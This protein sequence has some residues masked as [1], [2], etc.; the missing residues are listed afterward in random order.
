MFREYLTRN[1]RTV[2]QNCTYTEDLKLREDGYTITVN[3]KGEAA[4]TYHGIRGKKYAEETLK[5]LTDAKGQTLICE[6][7]DYPSFA[8]RGIIEGFYGKPYTWEE[9][10]DAIDFMASHKMN[11]YF[12]APKEDRYHRDL[13]RESYPVDQIQMIGEMKRR[14]EEKYVR[15]YYCMSPGKDF[16]FT[17][18]A[19]YQSLLRKFEEVAEVGVD[20]FAILFDDISAEL[21]EEEKIH[22]TSAAHAHCH[23][24]NWLNKHLKH[25]HKLVICPTDYMQNY[26]TPYREDLRKYL[27]A[28]IQVFWTGY[29]AV[30]EVLPER[31]CIV[32]RDTFQRE[33]V[34]WDNYPVNDYFPRGR[35]YMDAICNRTRNIA[36]YHEG[37]VSNTSGLW[38]SSKFMLVSF[39]KWM[40]NAE[41]YDS[42]QAYL[43]TLDELVG[44]DEKMR[45]FVSLNRT[46]TLRVYPDNSELFAAENWTALDG[47]YRKLRS[48]IMHIKKVCG[49][50]LAA[51]W[52]GLF[53]YGMLECRLY[54]ALRENKPLQPILNKIK[55]EHYHFADQSLLLYIE[56]KGL[57][58]A[59]AR[60]EKEVFWDKDR[61]DKERHRY[62]SF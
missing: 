19:D 3:N 10:F 51:E 1:T 22:F 42:E 21:T 18:E 40:W 58:E 8:L 50:A 60:Y 55:K 39:A 44:D 41:N 57:G 14:A 34:L 43:D 32:A 24:A 27:D 56:E 47:Y 25:T 17:C 46:S 59:L 45:F 26:D 12:Y 37:V 48:A 23:V 7:E 36:A 4:V 6:I 52:Q 2:V 38:Q 28:D 31:D 11:A 15:F 35:V 5:N 54:K 61:S 16:R 29:N 62:A 20:E 13:W 49:A 33:L 9:R 30:T 53:N